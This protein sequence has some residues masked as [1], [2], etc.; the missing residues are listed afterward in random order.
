MLTCNGAYFYNNAKSKYRGLYFPNEESLFK[1]ID[2]INIQEI[3]SIN[4]N[5]DHIEVVSKRG[6]IRFRFSKNVLFMDCDYKGELLFTLDVR[7]IYDFEDKGRIYNITEGKNVC[8][9]YKKFS[10]NQLENISFSK[11]LLIKTTSKAERIEKWREEFYEEDEARNSNPAR[12][13]VYDAFK[14]KC[15]GTDRIKI[16]F[17]DNI[18]ETEKRLDTDYE[19]MEVKT[20]SQKKL[21]DEDAIAYHFAAKSV[22]DLDVENKGLYAG[23]PWFFQV[24]TRDEAISLKALIDLKDYDFCRLRLMEMIKHIGMDGK[25]PNR[26]P[27][28]TLA[29]ADGT[30]WVFFRLH[31]LM[32]K[33]EETKMME[34]FFSKKNVEFIREQVRTSIER[35]KPENLLI[36][37]NALETW[38]DTSYENDT[39]EGFRIEIQALWLATLRFSNY[40]DRIS[41]RKEAYSD[42]EKGTRKKVREMFYSSGKLKDGSSDETI[43]PNVFL[44]HYVYPQLLEKEEWENVFDN[45]LDKLWL[46]WGGLASIDKK[47]KLFCPEYTGENNKS[48]HRGDSWFFMNNIAAICLNSIDR[49]KYED[50]IEKIKAA[51][52]RDILWKGIL[53][54]SSEISSAKEQRA[55]GS[56]FQLWSCATY[57]ELQ[58]V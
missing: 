44:A 21:Q 16:A 18:N 5:G 37:N 50:K 51:S 17:G 7:D 10:D 23:L 9:E 19:Q 1:T 12:L 25:I 6:I 34:Q 33:A 58:N 43:R 3:T 47:S 55:E 57:I 22:Y 13:Y 2:F 8:V 29:T 38:M 49:K 31:E 11:Y 14:I 35:H 36:R 42:T 41:G 54:R 39:R 32:I 48:Y 46:E 15:N 27:N 26:F 45:A 52:K 53:G 4:Y 40:L 28:S 30:G 24:W 20:F 56:L